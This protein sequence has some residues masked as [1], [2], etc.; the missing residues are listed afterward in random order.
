MNEINGQGQLSRLEDFIQLAKKGNR[1]ELKVDLRK[2]SMMQNVDS[3]EA[4]GK[5]DNIETYI[6]VA[7]YTFTMAGRPHKVSKVY[8]YAVAT[9]SRK[10]TR[11]SAA[12]ANLRLQLDYDRLKAA[13]IAFS[14]AFF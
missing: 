5:S 2:Q 14:E 7:D 12:I 11:A 10:T 13:N 6:L 9:E 1:I 4:D 8:M 3:D